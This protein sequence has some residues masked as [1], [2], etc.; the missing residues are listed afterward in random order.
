MII[1]GLLSIVKV[2]INLLFGWVSLPQVPEAVTSV[3]DTLFTY[4]QQGVGILWLFVPQ[5]LVRVLLPLV[6]V[7]HNFDHLYKLGMWILRKIPMVGI[8]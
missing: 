7:V 2:L 1:S 3:V 5:T 4:M 6:I 8:D